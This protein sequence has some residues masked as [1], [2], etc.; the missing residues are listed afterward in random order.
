LLTDTLGCLWG[1]DRSAHLSVLVGPEQASHNSPSAFIDLVD[2]LLHGLSTEPGRPEHWRSLWLTLRH[3]TL[4]APAAERLDGIFAGLDMDAVI[5][6]APW[7]LIPLM[8]LAVRHRCHREA[9]AA[10][11]YRWADG[12]DAGDQPLPGYREW[13]SAESRK[14]FG[15]WLMHWLHGLATRHPEEPDTEF[16]RLL[17]GLVLRSRSLAEDLIDPLTNITRPNLCA[18]FCTARLRPKTTPPRMPVSRAES[19]AC[20]TG[21]ATTRRSAGCGHRRC[22]RPT[23]RATSGD[24]RPNISLTIQRDSP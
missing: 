21:C 24:T 3:A 20:R 1:G 23:S 14:D 6:S 16:A 9:V 8:D 12:V 22:G 5:A 2:T 17:D 13:F 4:P 18:H 15:E 11:I 7:L 19:R 10:Q